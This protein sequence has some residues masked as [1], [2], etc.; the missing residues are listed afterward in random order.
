MNWLLENTAILNVIILAFQLIL[1][2]GQLYLAWKINKQTTSRD[3]GY[4]LLTETN[5]PH[6]PGEDARYR[7]EFDLASPIGFYVTG[8]SDVI[9]RGSNISIDG[10]NHTDAIPRNVYFTL[11]KRANRYRVDL[12]LKET[13]LQKDYVDVEF[14]F[15]LKNPYGYRYTEKTT[16][17]FRRLQERDSC[18]SL[19]KYNIVFEEK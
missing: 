7:N 13:D 15:R 3:K 5:L 8:G 10:R 16:T 19:E 6:L 17:R 4:F 14:N 12:E 18:W 9:V 11:D 1:I 2:G